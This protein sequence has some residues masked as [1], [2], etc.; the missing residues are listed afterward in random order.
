ML[1]SGCG[2]PRDILYRARQLADGGLKKLLNELYSQVTWSD[3][4]RLAESLFHHRT[5]LCDTWQHVKD[6][7][8]ESHARLDER[9]GW[10]RP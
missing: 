4:G 7:P 8:N 6:F 2:E 1:C 9:T 3:D 5:Q 10:N